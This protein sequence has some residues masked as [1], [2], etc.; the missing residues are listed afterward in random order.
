MKIWIDMTNSPHVLFFEPII[1]ELKK[2]HK[3]IVTARDYQQTVPLL[4]QKKIPFIQ[5]GKHHG[6]NMISKM[7]GYIHEVLI[8]IKFIL[9]IKPDLTINHHGMYATMAA[10]LTGNK[11]VY[12]FDGDGSTIQMSDILFAN[13]SLCP[14]ALP[15]KI[16]NKK[17][18]KYPGIKEEVYLSNFKPNKSYPKKLGIKR[19][20][21]LIRP[22]ATTATYIKKANMLD[23][24]ITD[25]IKQNKYDIVITPRTEQQRQYYKKFKVIIPNQVIDGPNLIANSSLMISG[26]GTMNREAVVLGIPVITF[27]PN[28]L[29][30]V[31]KWLVKNNYMKSIKNPTLKDI[32]ETIKTTKKYKRSD[33]GKKFILKTINSMLN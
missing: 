7:F 25:I 4:K 10:F 23:K 5:L 18:I 14:E 15:N 6:K 26:G 11:V 22:E 21:I 8:R 13:K 20:Y 17:L 24:L 3:I 16:F 27:F 12:I 28:I 30:S 19:K 31:D 33:K 29:L 32:K 1:K 9:K 2:K